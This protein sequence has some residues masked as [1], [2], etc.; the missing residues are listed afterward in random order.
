MKQKQR[1][2]KLFEEFI[3]NEEA[4]TET[5]AEIGT[6]DAE[7][8]RKDVEVPERSSAVVVKEFFNELEHNVHYWFKNGKL[9][10]KYNLIDIEV[11]K[12]G[13]A[14]WM[15]DYINEDKD[16]TTPKYV[17]RVKYYEGDPKGMI[18]NVEDVMF[19]LDIYNH[20]KS[21]NM[22]QTRLNILAKKINEDF[23]LDRIKRTVSKIV[24]DPA[25]KKEHDRFMNRQSS[26]LTDEYY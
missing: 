3:L 1:N 15:E 7:E 16:E 12:Q 18:S 23:L 20:D 25:D 24:K 6:E 9:G 13:L 26:R 4:E 14:I 5:D 21:V 22:K 2:I 10:K 8:E 19:T 11:E 17:Y